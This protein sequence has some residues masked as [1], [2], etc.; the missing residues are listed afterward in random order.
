MPLTKNDTSESQQMMHHSKQVN[1]SAK[2]LFGGSSAED[3]LMSY[4]E[5]KP[6]LGSG[7]GLMEDENGEIEDDDDQSYQKSFV[8]KCK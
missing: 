2:G 8:N 1:S 5:E 7:E 6:Q 4:G 3:N